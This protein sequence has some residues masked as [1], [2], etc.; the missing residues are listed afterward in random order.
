MS[1]RKRSGDDFDREIRAHLEL[2]TDRLIE[3]GL[4]PDE[5]RARA[6]RVFGSV[7]HSRERFYERSRWLWFD[8]LAQDLRCGWRGL[9]RYPLAATV[10]VVSLAGGIGAAT[11]T[12]MVRDVMF[13]N[14]PPLY[15]EPAQISRV[16]VGTP[17]RPI[18]PL[19]NPVPAGVY[20]RWNES[21]D[22]PVA[23]AAASHLRDVRAGDRV[24]PLPV[25]A[26]TPGL[27]ELLGVGP[28]LGRLLPVGPA[29]ADAPSPVV[30]SDRAWDRLFDR[31]GDAIGQ[32]IWIENRPSTVVGVMPRRFWFSEMNSPIWTSLD[33]RAT[34]DAEGLEV[35]ARRPAGLTERAL[36]ARLSTGLEAYAAGLP[37]AERRL[38][39]RA[40]DIGGIP[41]GRQMAPILP[42]LLA[43]AVLLTLLIACANVAILMI[44][45][46]TAREHEMAIRASIGA[47][48]A[49]IVRTLL[50]ES[51]LVAALGGAAGVAATLL[52][53][54]W[55]VSRG[56]GAG[57]DQFIDVSINP[58]VFVQ[59]A[60]I[61]IVTGVIAGV[62]PA[63]YETR[64]LHANPLRTL[65]TS[66]RVR[67]RW[68]HALVI[69]EIT[70]TVALFVV[71]AAMIDG[72]LR[73]RGAELGFAIQPLASASIENPGGVAIGPTL[74]ALSHV[75]GVASVA[76]ATAMPFR[77]SGIGGTTR[78]A[79]DAAGANALAAERAAITPTFFA[80]LGVVMRE[81]RAF[82]ASDTAASRIVILN[83]TAARRV[84]GDAPAAGR[85]VWI[86]DVPYDVV[87]VV[88]DYAVNPMQ[89]FAS[90]PKLFVPLPNDGRTLHRVNVLIRA[91]GDPGPLIPPS[92]RAAEAATA[93]THFE[94]G[95]TFEDLLT[96]GAQEMLVGTA[97][98]VPLNAIGTLLSTT[99]IY[100]VLA[101]AIARRSREL[102]VRMAIGA[103]PADIVRLVLTQTMRLAGTGTALGI[104][105]T[106]LLG[107]VVRASGGA[108][109]IYDPGFTAFAWPLAAIVVLAAIA[110]WIPSRRAVRIDPSAVLRTS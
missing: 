52:L 87:G 92:R 37:L 89:A 58:A 62:A 80:T 9:R 97:P 98:L 27:F 55:V 21:L 11:V 73:L 71:T 12:L 17:E 81:G 85:R 1:T 20:R 23:A 48:R 77:R 24:Q 74:D 49:R 30:L 19:G 6:A 18:M 94:S 90:S 57:D 72:Y 88:A 75:P 102:A 56:G 96:V 63:M 16:Q 10:A 64:R 69:G 50:T 4:A 36:E 82:A 105:A 79:A 66:D 28:E 59:A 101:F 2:E 100:G 25:R 60:L 3:D 34:D 15:V 65:A 41:T 93:G 83:E 76:A 45:Q 8:R 33:V 13:R 103:S 44:A 29:A 91:E 53:R 40:S 54:A 38:Q 42:Y 7:T 22:V 31:R 78:I 84:F 70:I 99:G 107:R 95:Y 110:T 35:I 106:F 68:R 32:T 104:G 51:V 61:T 14:P 108:G 39:L 109:T 86:G 43:S 67:Q 47:S 5:A 46:W 26:V